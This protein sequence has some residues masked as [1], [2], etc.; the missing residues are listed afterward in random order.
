MAEKKT[1]MV[2]L[3]SRRNGRDVLLR[4]PYNVVQ[5]G[6]VTL[7]EGLRN[8]TLR[9]LPAGRSAAG[10]VPEGGAMIYDGVR[11]YDSPPFMPNFRMG[12]A[13]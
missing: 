4:E 6:E 10:A 1:F 7:I 8:D 5:Y 13:L 3:R 2:F 12:S 11:V 9:H